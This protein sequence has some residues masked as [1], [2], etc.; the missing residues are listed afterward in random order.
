MIQKNRVVYGGIVE[1]QQ[2]IPVDVN[3]KKQIVYA[4]PAKP[5]PRRPWYD[6]PLWLVIFWCLVAAILIGMN[7]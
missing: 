2:P 3:G 6:S 5:K 7:P 1:D 4:I